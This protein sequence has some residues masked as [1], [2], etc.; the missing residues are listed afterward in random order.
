M[1]VTF[2]PWFCAMLNSAV[3]SS[4]GVVP[5]ALG[6]R[7]NRLVQF[8]EFA[9]DVFT[10]CATTS[11]SV[12]NFACG[13]MLFEFP[14]ATVGAWPYWIFTMLFA[15]A[16]A[17]AS[18]VAPVASAAMWNASLPNPLIEYAMATVV[19]SLITRNGTCAAR[20]PAAGH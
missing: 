7:L 3:D 2:C 18:A 4:V 13:L 8:D 1:A 14:L 5:A 15:F 6:A 9:L 19:T 12:Y 16:I 11:A 17:F 20:F 10:H